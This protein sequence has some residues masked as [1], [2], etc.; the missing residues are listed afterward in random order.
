[1]KE[2]P[3]VYVVLTFGYGGHVPTYHNL[4][5]RGVMVSGVEVVSACG[6]NP[7]VSAASE[8]WR[9]AGLNIDRLRLPVIPVMKTEIAARSAFRFLNWLPMR[10]RV[11][12]AL[13]EVGFL[14]TRRARQRWRDTVQ[15]IHSVEAM[16]PG[17]KLHVLITYIDEYLAPGV[18]PAEVDRMMP[19]DWSCFYI[20]AERNDLSL[21]QRARRAGWEQFMRAKTCRAIGVLDADSAVLLTRNI[22]AENVV[23]FPDVVDLTL[24]DLNDEIAAEIHRRSNGRTVLGLVGQITPRKNL[25]MFVEMTKLCH[26]DRYFFA[27]VGECEQMQFPKAIREW[28]VKGQRGE[29]GNVFVSPRRVAGDSRFNAVCAACDILFAAYRDFRGSSN[30]IGKA[31]AFRKPIIVGRGYQMEQ[32]VRKWGTGVAIDERMAAQGASALDSIVEAVSNV[33]GPLKLDYAGYLR[34]ISMEAFGQSVLRLVGL[35]GD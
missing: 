7:E 6:W 1:M 27:V 3:C 14:R 24:P 19:C 9:K 8:S 4:F 2:R 13:R 16:Y 25:E 21:Q 23:Q 10:D 31:A 5:L 15:A 20:N 12:K 28:L 22:G 18:S 32:I 29:L 11:W 33:N 34:S 30:V 26:S 17:S 35:D